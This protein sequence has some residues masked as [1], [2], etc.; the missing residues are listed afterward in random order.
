MIFDTISK[1]DDGLRF[2]K[3]R[4]DNKRK[5]LLQLNGVKVVDVSDEEVV[6]DLVSETAAEKVS[7]IDAQNVDAALEH[8]AEWF[9]KELP[10]SVVRGAYTPS[11]TADLLIECERIGATKIFDSQQQ[12]V[13]I[14]SLQKDRTCD[15]IL[16]FSGIWFA[17]KN[18]AATWN[19]VQ[20]RLHPEPVLDT[21]PDEY[22][23]VDQ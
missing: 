14:D 4:G 22:A 20:V 11:A 13:D 23:F 15:V 2:V 16:E 10:E 1:N 3:A 6:F 5:V 8:S 19:L 18:F 7:A 9:G 12:A 17:K 21:Y